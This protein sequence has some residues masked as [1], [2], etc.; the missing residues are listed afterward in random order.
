MNEIQ[1]SVNHIEKVH[2]GLY[3]K[4]FNR[5]L[6]AGKKALLRIN[7][8]DI[9]ELEEQIKAKRKENKKL[10]SEIW[11]YLRITKDDTK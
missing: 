3:S 1:K 5:E 11:A 9:S 4:T 2:S 7:L 10:R 6:L 8:K